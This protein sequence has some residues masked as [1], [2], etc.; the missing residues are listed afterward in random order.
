MI[1]LNVIK[2]S[3]LVTFIN[4]RIQRFT[5]FELQISMLDDTA[6]LLPR[7]PT[8]VTM[9]TWIAAQWR[10][11]VE[12]VFCFGLFAEI[13]P[14]FYQRRNQWLL[15]KPFLSIPSISC[16]HWYYIPIK[17]A[18]ATWLLGYLASMSH[19]HCHFLYKRT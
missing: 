9:G 14:S 11:P 4:V 19:C 8:C 18:L 1:T 5:P 13:G 15:V 16:F 10:Y 3:I 17:I 2:I 7:S 6:L 12:L